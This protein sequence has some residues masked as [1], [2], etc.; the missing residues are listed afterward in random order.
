VPRE[1]YDAGLVVGATNVPD[2]LDIDQVNPGTLIVDDSAPH[3]FDPDKAKQRLEARGDILFTA[4]GVIRLPE[5]FQRTLYLPQRVKDQMPPAVFESMAQ[6]NPFHIGGCVLSALLTARY[7]SLKPT[8]GIVDDNSCAQHYQLLQQLGF[9]A[10][11]PQCRGYTLPE[12][13]V[14]RFRKRFGYT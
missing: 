12:E 8:L 2:V 5:P 4:G 11:A 9:Q 1:I 7:E 3:C 6:D 13:S 10:A 14:R